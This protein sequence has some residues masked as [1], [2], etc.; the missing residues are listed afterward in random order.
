MTQSVSVIVGGLL[1]FLSVS[2]GLL[3][4]PGVVF[5]DIA[6]LNNGLSEWGVTEGLQS[7]LILL[8]ALIGFQG[9]LS[10]PE[11]RS[12]LILVA[13]FFLCMF[14]R[15]QDRLLDLVF[16]GL[17]QLLVFA[18]ATISIVMSLRDR[19]TLISAMAA[20]CQS[21]AFSHVL[22]GIALLL[23]FSRVFGTGALWEEVLVGV[24]AD[25]LHQTKTVVQEGLEL[26]G[27]Y[28]IFYGSLMF[29]LQ[30]RRPSMAT[31]ASKTRVDMRGYSA[32]HEL[33]AG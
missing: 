14:F 11:Q 24:D 16:D 17:W 6:W 25:V 30:H 5:V 8:S 7:L 33:N 28:F 32:Q 31:K 9:A 29:W 1:R 22:F 15:E 20:A 13:G 12:F 10:R 18:T 23:C 26:C 3:L 19:R 21:V 2:L 27:Y 4:V